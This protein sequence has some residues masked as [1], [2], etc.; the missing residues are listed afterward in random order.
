MWWLILVAL[1]VASEASALTP[2][3]AVPPVIVGNTPTA[4]SAFSTSTPTQTYTRTPTRTLT[5]TPTRTA[6]PVNTATATATPTYLGLRGRWSQLRQS[7]A[8]WHLHT[9]S[10]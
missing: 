1:A 8:V 7:E 4:T 5:R 6:T 2:T 3:P 10:P 9:V